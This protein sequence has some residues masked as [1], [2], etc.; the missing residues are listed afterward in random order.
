VGGG[1]PEIPVFYYTVEVNGVKNHHHD[2]EPI[3]VKLKTL[4]G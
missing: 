2:F 4:D 1:A 3:K